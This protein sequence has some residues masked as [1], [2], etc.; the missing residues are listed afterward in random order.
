M[1]RRQRTMSRE[2]SFSTQNFS[3]GVSVGKSLEMSAK[4][5]KEKDV[6]LKRKVSTFAFVALFMCLIDFVRNSLL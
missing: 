1:T 5:S 6:N 2:N 3:F 4:S